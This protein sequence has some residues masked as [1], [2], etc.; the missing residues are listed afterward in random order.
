MLQGLRAR[1]GAL[2]AAKLR[3]PL[4]APTKKGKID[5]GQGRLLGERASLSRLPLHG[6]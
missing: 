4:P 6:P 2:A 3:A 5:K 1:L